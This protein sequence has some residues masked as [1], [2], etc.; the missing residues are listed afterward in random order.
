MAGRKGATKLEVADVYK[1][2][3]KDSIQ[4]DYRLISFQQFLDLVM[5]TIQYS[6]YPGEINQNQK[7]IANIYQIIETLKKE[8][9]DIRATLGSNVKDINEQM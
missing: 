1:R 6:K 8:D 4:K 5:C 3:L 2:I 9:K 7:D